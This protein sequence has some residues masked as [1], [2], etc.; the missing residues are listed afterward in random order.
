MPNH[1]GILRSLAAS[2]I[3]LGRVEEASAVTEKILK[4][5]PEFSLDQFARRTER[6]YKN[7]ADV[8]RYI[9]ALRKAGLK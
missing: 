1:T 5:R 7:E 6:I 2:Y 4:L 8:E 9:D 3:L